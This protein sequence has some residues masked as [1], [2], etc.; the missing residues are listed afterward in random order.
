MIF[1]LGGGKSKSSG[2]GYQKNNMVFNVQVTKEAFDEI[3]ENLPKIKIPLT[4]W[5]DKKDMTDE[6][7]IKV[8][9]WDTMGGYLKTLSYKD[10]WAKAWDKMSQAD[11]NKILTIPHF[12]AEIFKEITG[13]YVESKKETIKIGNNTY[14]KDEVEEALK[15]VKSL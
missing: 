14:N 1:C 7:K 6:E 8:N 11:K 15:D 13:I 2:D 12:D 10:A 4:H 9:G 3:E 5:V